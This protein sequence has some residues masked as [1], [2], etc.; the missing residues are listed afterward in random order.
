M[1]KQTKWKSI[2]RDLDPSV[3]SCGSTSSSAS[4]KLGS[5]ASVSLPVTTASVGD[6]HGAPSS[7][8]EQSTDSKG[9]E[10]VQ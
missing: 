6:L 4:C 7:L 9:C 8:V 5:T 3:Q 1:N 10:S 2:K